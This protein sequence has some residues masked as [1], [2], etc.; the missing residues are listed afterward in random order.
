MLQIRANERVLIAGKTGS[1]K[2]WLASRL[3]AGVRRLVVLD[4]KA[5][6]DSWNLVQPN[7]WQWQQ[8]SRGKAGRFRILPP[9]TPDPAGWYETLFAR[10]YAIGDLTLYID[11]AYA[12]VPP[13]SRPGQW[14]SALYTRGRERGIGVW[15]ATQ[16]PTWIPLFL[17][18]EADW[19]LIFRLNLDADRQRLANLAGDRVLQKIPDQHGFFVYHIDQDQAVYYRQAIASR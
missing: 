7:G 10:L 11:E 3:L 14:L 17:L 19:F 18:S 15:A 12:V 1:G 6:L 8:F 2:T 9:I 5:N 13:G 4:P 16:R